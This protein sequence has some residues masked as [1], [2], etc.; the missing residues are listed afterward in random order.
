MTRWL[1]STL[2]KQLKGRLHLVDYTGAIEPW[3]SA[4][5]CLY[6]SSREDPFPSV[7]LEALCVGLPV[8][9]HE[10]AT[11]FDESILALLSQAPL[12]DT[13]AL[14]RAL[15]LAA[16]ED[17]E[18][19]QRA[20]RQHVRTH[21]RLQDYGA[22]LLALAGM[23]LPRIAPAG[24]TDNAFENATENAAAAIGYRSAANG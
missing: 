24:A 15:R 17:D 2:G 22:A 11:G 23:Q 18:T 5:D 6:L 10:G 14:D 9:L 8:V 12:N 7:V 16:Y 1:K 4:A 3:Y 20:R 13:I 19:L 21:Y